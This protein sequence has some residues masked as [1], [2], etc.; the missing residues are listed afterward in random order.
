[1]KKEK[2]EKQLTVTMSFV[3]EEGKIVFS[4]MEEAFTKLNQKERNNLHARIMWAVTGKK[5]KAL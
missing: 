4:S 1:M 2:G 3:D 5:H